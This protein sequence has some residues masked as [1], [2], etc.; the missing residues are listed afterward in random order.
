MITAIAGA[1]SRWSRSLGVPRVVSR[2]LMVAGRT[3]PDFATGIV[4]D[5]DGLISTNQHV[6]GDP[7]R[8]DYVVWVDNAILIGPKVKAAN[9]YYDLAILHIDRRPISRRSPW[10]TLGGIKEGNWYWPWGIPGPLPRTAV[11]VRPGGSFRIST[12]GP[13]R[14]HRGGPGRQSHAAPFWGTDP[15]GRPFSA[16]GTS[17]GGLPLNL[18]GEL[19]GITSSLAALEGGE[20]AAGFAIRIGAQ[21]REVIER[22]KQG[23]GR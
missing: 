4:V 18:E 10:A 7:A 20:Q 21:M 23:L 19:I 6:V 3:P 15:N 1:R 16:T 13:S 22:L 9:P 17:G 8:H 12:A 2:C 11:P 14:F 5:A